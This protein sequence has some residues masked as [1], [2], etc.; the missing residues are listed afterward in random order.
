MKAL[1][2]VLAIA[3]FVVAVL[4]WLPN[5]PFGHHLKHGIL[6]AILGIL[7]LVWMRFQSSAPARR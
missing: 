4:Y 2:L 7:A 3:F 6:F 5:G 1:A